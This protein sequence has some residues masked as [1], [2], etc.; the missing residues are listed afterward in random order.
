M[1]GGSV[2]VRSG[3]IDEDDADDLDDDEARGPYATL[4]PYDARAPTLERCGALEAL[5]RLVAPE[6]FF[7]WVDAGADFEAHFKLLMSATIVFQDYTACLGL[8]GNQIFNP[9]SMCA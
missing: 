1:G 7:A 4:P 9:T 8:R 6:I 2:R 5:L 3:D